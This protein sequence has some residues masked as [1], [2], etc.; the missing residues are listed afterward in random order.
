MSAF[1]LGVDDLQHCTALVREQ[2][3]DV[4][5][6]NLLLP[7]ELRDCIMVLN[8][9]HI[10]V[11]NIALAVREPMASEIRLQWWSEVIAGRRDDDALGHPI[12]RA[13]LSV[14]EAHGLS[15]KAF[16]AKLEAHVFDLY[17]DPMGDRQMFEGWC[18]ETRSVLFQMASL[19]ADAEHGPKLADASGHSGVASGIVAV[20]QQLALHTSSGRVFLPSDIL[21]EAGL[22][23]QTFLTTPHDAHFHAVSAMIERARHHLIKAEQA[24][25]G[26]SAAHKPVFLPMALVPLYLD[27]MERNNQRAFGG[28]PPVSQLKRQWRLWRAS[29][30]AYR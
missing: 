18:G 30:R 23:P 3:Q 13:L 24:I 14:I 19:I 5:L 11:S 8:A 9:F 16:E 29:R 17:N 27:H 1:K 7:V 4:Y 15:R 25:A 26:L 10:D 22:T 28:F 21:A 12:A 2:A 6:A 20:L